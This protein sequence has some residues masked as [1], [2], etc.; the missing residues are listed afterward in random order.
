MNNLTQLTQDLQLKV[1]T[2]AT[3]L[4]AG[5]IM[6]CM[7]TENNKWSDIDPCP[8][9]AKYLVTRIDMEFKKYVCGR[10]VRIFKRKG[11]ARG[12]GMWVIQA[13]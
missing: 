3:V 11:H 13:L 10:H 12:F 1:T 4:I 8:C 7:E 9:P 6:N 2:E 5:K